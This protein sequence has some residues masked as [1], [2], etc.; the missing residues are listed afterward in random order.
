MGCFCFFDC[1]RTK[2]PALGCLAAHLPGCRCSIGGRV[3]LGVLCLQGAKPDVAD[4]TACVG[5]VFDNPARLIDTALNGVLTVIR[6]RCIALCSTVYRSLWLRCS[7][8][9]FSRISVS[10]ITRAYCSGVAFM[11]MIPMRDGTNTTGS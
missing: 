2:A 7:L 5:C 3:I 11:G 6:W 4:S 8:P 1:Q 10:L 9:A